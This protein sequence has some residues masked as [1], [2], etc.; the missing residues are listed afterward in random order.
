MLYPQNGATDEELRHDEHEQIIRV[1]GV[2]VNRD[3]IRIQIW[4]HGLRGSPESE[5]AGDG[6]DRR[7]GTCRRRRREWRRAAE[8]EMA[9]EAGRRGAT[10]DG[11]RPGHG[12]AYRRGAAA[13]GKEARWRGRREKRLGRGTTMWARRHVARPGWPEA[14]ADAVR[15]GTDVS[16][17]TETIFLGFGRG[18]SGI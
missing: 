10:G 16:G 9:G 13:A 15:P 12:G 8:A 5:V 14:A 3:G 1:L 6:V 11:G 2:K 4:P 18:R 7:S 17:A